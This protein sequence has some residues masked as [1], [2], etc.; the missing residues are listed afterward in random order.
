MQLKRESRL[1]TIVIHQFYPKKEI[2]NNFS[3]NNNS[4][5]VS[6]KVINIIIIFKT[7]KKEK[8]F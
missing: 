4:N 7:K 2:T 1:E 8:K 6:M 3:K 5:K